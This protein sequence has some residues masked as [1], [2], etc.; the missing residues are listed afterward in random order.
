M[1]PR[2]PPYALSS[3]ISRSLLREP[4]PFGPGSCITLL[5]CLD[6]LILFSLLSL[7]FEVPD[8]THLCIRA[9]FLLFSFQG[10]NSSFAKR[11]V[12]G[13]KEPSK[14]NNNNQTNVLDLEFRGSFLPLVS[15][16]RR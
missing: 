3:L 16:E 4:W 8:T 11:G 5:L 13:Y 12:E 6:S 7:R 2:H 10:A 1:A 15:L 14:L 9:S